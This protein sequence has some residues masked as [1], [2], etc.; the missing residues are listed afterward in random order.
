MTYH[1]ITLG[2]QMNKADSERLSAYLET[3]GGV[4]EVDMNKPEVVVLVTCGVR[5]SAENRI[6]ALAPKI[7]QT[8]PDAKI[9]LT[10]CL[11]ARLDVQERLK[12]YIDIWLDIVDLPLLATRLGLSESQGS[13]KC[14]LSLAA[15]YQ[16]TF[17]AYV[18]V[19]NGCNNF[20]AYCVVPYARGRETYR[21]YQE[22]V[23]EVKTLL[24][25]GY[26]EIILIAQN[27]NSYVSGEIDFADLLAMIDN[28]AGDFWIRFATSH[29]K[30]LSDKLIEVVA[31]SKK[32]CPHWHIALQS[33]SDEVL[34][35][36][37]RKYTAE[38]FL[39][40][41][42]KIRAFNPRSAITTDIIVG[43]PGETHEQFLQTKKLMATVG[44]AQAYISRYSPRPGTVAFKLSDNILPAEKQSRE[45]E[46]ETVLRANAKKFN[47]Q[48][49][50]QVTPVLIEQKNGSSYYGKN[51]YFTT[52][53][54]VAKQD[55]KIGEVAP[56]KITEANYF[57]LKGEV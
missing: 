54:F 2:C 10:G 51:A 37:N 40:L 30:D 27:V 35:L 38:H 32:I 1:V 42:K 13:T 11:S 48:F 4:Y 52:V 50:G 19:G 12:D 33:G 18:P 26:K 23:A 20:C 16:S 36:M 25:K 41:V 44:F 15:K 21:P 17:S 8:N 22:I 53:R 47:A 45:K 14:Y 28:L 56:V 46:L 5:Q 55:Y 39:N 31:Q 57:S 29:P 9:V 7:K 43:F 24:A 6:Y 34:K 49:V 3:L